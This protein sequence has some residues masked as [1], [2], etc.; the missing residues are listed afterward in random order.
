MEGKENY[1]PNDEPLLKVEQKLDNVKQKFEENT[2]AMEMLKELKKTSKRWFI[3][4]IVLLIAL[5]GT[6]IGWL[7]Y[8]SQFE[9][10]I[11]ETTQ[12]ID[13]IQNADNSNFTQTIN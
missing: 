11:E 7:I 9:T 1:V 2:L 10:V 3:I 13:D 4:A 6:N 12:T 8:E 5:V